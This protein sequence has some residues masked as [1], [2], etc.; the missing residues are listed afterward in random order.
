MLNTENNSTRGMRVIRSQVTLISSWASGALRSPALQR[1]TYFPHM[2]MI[3]SASDTA[4]VPP[5]VKQLW[6]AVV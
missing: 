6:G 1:A 3:E 5:E 2:G 4:R